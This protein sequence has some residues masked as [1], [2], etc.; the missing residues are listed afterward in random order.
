[1]YPTMEQVEAADR[2]QL[3]GWMRF[4]PSPGAS[5]KR[6]KDFDEALVREKVILDKIAERFKEMGGM[7]PE[8]SKQIGWER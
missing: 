6:M 5:V 7:T 8:I 1:M 3:A 2:V 4:L